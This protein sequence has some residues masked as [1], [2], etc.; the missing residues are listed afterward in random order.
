MM[1]KYICW[2]LNIY[3]ANTINYNFTSPVNVRDH[4]EAAVSIIIPHEVELFHNVVG[5]RFSLEF[6]RLN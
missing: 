4:P 1:T 6:V 5:E 2:I 3:I